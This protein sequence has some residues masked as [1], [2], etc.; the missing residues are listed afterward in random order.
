MDPKSQPPSMRR[1]KLMNRGK[2]AVFVGY[3]DRTTKAWMFWEPDMKTVRQ[4]S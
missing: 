1:D 2:E 4:H 3:V